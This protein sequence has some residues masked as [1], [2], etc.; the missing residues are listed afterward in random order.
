MWDEEWEKHLLQVALGRIKRQVHP[1]HYEI[2]HLHVI[3]G[4][5]VREVA[6]ALGVNVAQVHLAKYRVGQLLKKE[7]RR[8]QGAGRPSG[9]GFQPVWAGILPGIRS[10]AGSPG[11][12]LEACPSILLSVQNPFMPSCRC[13]TRR[14]CG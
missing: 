14:A 4:Q 2:Y 13:S 3:L 5:P 11:D 9:A 12:R 8:L 1:R 6:R 10:G 7:I